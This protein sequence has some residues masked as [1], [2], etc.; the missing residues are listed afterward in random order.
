MIAPARRAAFDALLEVGT[1]RADLPHALAR[2]RLRLPDERDRALAGEIAA[3]TLRWQGAFDHVIEQFARRPLARLD[4]EIVVILRLAMFQLLHLDRVPASAAVNDAVSLA[5]AAGKRSAAPLVNAV[6]R[7]VSRERGRLPLPPRP[8]PDGSRTAVLDYLSITLS[9][10]RWLAARWLDRYGFEAVEAWARFNNTP[11]ALTLRAN[12]LRIGAPDL[13][14][15]LA[16]HGVRTRPGR[17]A[18]DALVIEAGNPLLTPLAGQ[19]LFT[20]QD[21]ASQLVTLVTAVQPG[22]RVLDACVSPGGKALAMAAAMG[23]RGLIVATDLRGR[24]VELL[25]RMIRE[26]GASSVRVVRADASGPLPF[27][28]AFDCVLLDAPCSGLGTIRRDPEIRWR[29]RE[30]DLAVL[31]AAQLRMLRQVAQ[32]VGP[33]GRMTYATCSSETEENEEVVDAFVADG[34]FE[35]L[36]PPGAVPPS[37]LDE[38]GRLKTLPFRDGLEAFFAAPLVRR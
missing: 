35:P 33:G 2:V 23:D 28:T 36:G 14:E 10:P 12:R 27:A 6:L 21:E 25:A 15:R 5:R 29:R 30:A 24:R 16:G 37:L 38:Q 18:P 9:H 11:A 22:E 31:A 7:R 3:G 1:E 32:V 20:V 34:G 8:P 26:A 19:G 13:A 4:P 17:F